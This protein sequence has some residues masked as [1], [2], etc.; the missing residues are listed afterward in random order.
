MMPFMNWVRSN[1]I[2]VISI[3]VVVVSLGALGWVHLNGTSFE[4]EVAQRSR[5]LDQIKRFERNSM[6]VPGERPDDPP[7]TISSI[8]IN[9]VAID[10]LKD[11][12]DRMLGEH[13]ALS[14]YALRRNRLGKAVLVEGLFPEPTSLNLPFDARAAYRAALSDLLKPADPED[15]SLPRLDAGRPPDQAFIDSELEEVRNTFIEGRTILGVAED[16]AKVG[17]ELVKEQRDRLMELLLE[18]AENIHLYAVTDIN[19]PDFP[20]DVGE[21]SAASAG[22]RPT[23]DQLWE[24]QIELWFQQDIAAA[25]AKANQ[26]WDPDA[27]V[28]NVPVKRLIR[29]EIV[30]GYIGLHTFGPTIADTSAA[31]PYSPPASGRTGAAE[32]PQPDNF[33]NGP[34]GR[35]SNAVYDVRQARVV[36]IADFQQLPTL[37]SAINDTN[38]LS[39]IDL[40]IT[41]VDEYL[42]LE[43]GFIY[44]SSDAVEVDMVIE[45]IWLRAWTSELMPPIVRQYVGIDEPTA[46]FGTAPDRPGYYDPRFQRDRGGRYDPYAPRNER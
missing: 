31:M 43:Q 2:T 17:T 7:E 12:Y 38:F 10:Q 25:I 33:Y 19:D 20:F 14:D 23:M 24:G 36:L 4:E 46:E 42:E 9:Q 21:W 37:F 16:S 35:T 15:P 40:Q 26:T 11:L 1:L 28:L 18:R 34:S 44:G 13:D 41:G 5:T 45:S 6:R 30:P 27:N 22:A 8:T 32:Q 3:I 29:V 39:V